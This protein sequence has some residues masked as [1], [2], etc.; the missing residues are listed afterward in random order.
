MKNWKDIQEEI[1]TSREPLKEGSWDEMSSMLRGNTLGRKWLWGLLLIPLF[2]GLGTWGYLNRKPSV[3]EP[4]IE[5]TSP[6]KA[7]ATENRE[8]PATQ[9]GV[10][11]PKN[12][13]N[14]D[15]EMIARTGGTD[16]QSP[17]ASLPGPGNT[18]QENIKER[19]FSESTGHF[20]GEGNLQWTAKGIATLNLPENPQLSL[21]D[22]SGSGETNPDSIFHRTNTAKPGRW[23]IRVFVGPTISL[24]TRKYDPEEGKTHKQF[25]QANDNAVIPGLGWDAGAELRYRVWKSFRLSSGLGINKVV[26]RNQYDYTVNEIP[27]IDSATGNIL[28]YIPVNSAQ[29]VTQGSNNIYNFINIPVSLYY[30]KPL[31]G[32][33]TFTAEAIH[34]TSILLSQSSYKLN[35]TTLEVNREEREEL[36]NMI[37]AFQLRLGLRYRVGSNF[38]LAVEPS[39]R[40][41]YQDV[42]KDSH[43]SWKPRDFSISLSGIVKLY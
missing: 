11:R 22:L 5:K 13:V 29:R 8:L 34:H 35:S 12:V 43:V 10:K 18:K 16:H 9:T 37:N 4:Q 17:D 1:R 39:Y 21:K 20:Q 33:W 3:T 28:A 2:L 40:A 32:R 26:T 23:E 7:G 14:E 25:D 24:N 31:M 6:V 42:F 19:D 38:Y 27:V 36:N 30:E 41:Y 15:T